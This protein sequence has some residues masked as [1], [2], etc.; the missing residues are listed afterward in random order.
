M[1]NNNNHCG[2][3]VVTENAQNMDV[4]VRGRTVPTD[5]VFCAHFK[6]SFTSGFE[7]RPAVC[8]VERGV[9]QHFFHRSST[10]TAELIT[11]PR[12]LNLP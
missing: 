3:A 10:A 1:K 8:L 11:K 6:P 9:Q 4:E 12:L 2:L 7:H 5:I